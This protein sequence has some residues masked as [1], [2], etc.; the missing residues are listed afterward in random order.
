MQKERTEGAPPAPT[1]CTRSHFASLSSILCARRAVL[2]LCGALAL[3]PAPRFPPGL[4]GP[5]APL[6]HPSPFAE[7]AVP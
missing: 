2:T 4:Q 1:H 3:L 6:T 5:P 7:A